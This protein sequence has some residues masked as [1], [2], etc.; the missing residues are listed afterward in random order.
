MLTKKLLIRSSMAAGAVLFLGFG[1][2]LT[3]ID[4]GH[5]GVVATFG[6]VEGEPLGEG[7]HLVYPFA[8]SVHKYNVQVQKKSTSTTAASKDLQQVTAEVTLNYS[9]NPSSVADI[10]TNIGS[11][12][13][14][15]FRLIEPAVQEAVKASAARYNAEELITKRPEV[16]ENIKVM[17]DERLTKYG[18]ITKDFSITDF[19]FSEKFNSAIEAKVTAEQEKLRAQNDLERIKIEAEQKIASANAEAESLRVQ[20]QQI[21][22]ELLELRKIE[23][24]REA[25]AKWNG[26]LPQYMLQETTPFLSVK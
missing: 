1:M 16:R 22:Q 12:D 18:V 2:P 25:I 17:V 24:Q 3:I 10:Y 8:D 6:K 23:A 19:D 21:T 26:A 15:Q 4:P 20:K 5:R 14:V 9:I 11:I 7:I 13:A